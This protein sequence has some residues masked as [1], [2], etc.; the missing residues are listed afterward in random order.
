MSWKTSFGDAD[1]IEMEAESMTTP[2]RE[3]RLSQ[4]QTLAAR[5]AAAVSGKAPT[6][7][8]LFSLRNLLIAG[9][10]LGGAYYIYKK[11]GG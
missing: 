9:A 2:A 7:S 3:A 5:A 8:G 11:R 6:P 4:E 10:V 1:E